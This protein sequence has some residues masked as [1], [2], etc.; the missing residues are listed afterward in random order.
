M[1][2]DLNLS[3][4]WIARTQLDLAELAIARHS[5]TDAATARD[6]IAQAQRGIDGYGYGGLKPQAERLLQPL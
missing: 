2:T 3:P 4:Y 6:F 1:G 5:P